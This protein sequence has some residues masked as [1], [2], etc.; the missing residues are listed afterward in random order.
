M[1]MFAEMPTRKL[2]NELAKLLQS[3]VEFVESARFAQLSGDQVKS[4]ARRRFLDTT[5]M[6][7]ATMRRLASVKS[8]GTDMYASAPWHQPALMPQP[9]TMPP[10]PQRRNCAT[11][12]YD[13]VAGEFISLARVVPVGMSPSEFARSKRPRVGSW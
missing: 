8:V 1:E 9:P 7:R 10:P 12:T 4:W 13:G 3:A 11:Q 2:V 6:A 5:A